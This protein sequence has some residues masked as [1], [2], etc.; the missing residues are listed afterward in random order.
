MNLPNPTQIDAILD[1]A[2]HEPCPGVEILFGQ[3]IGPM[4][5]GR[6]QHATI[7]RPEVP[8]GAPAPAL[9]ALHGGG[10]QQGDPNGCGERGK[11]LAIALGMTTVSVSYRL[12]GENSPTFPGVLEDVA[13]GWRWVHQRAES[14]GLDPSRVAVS[15]SSAGV[16]LGAH[17]V[18][19]S[20]L[21]AE[22]VAGYPSPSAFVA[23]WGPLDLVARWFDNGE[24][25]GA[26]NMLLGTTYSADPALY[27]QASPLTHVRGPLPPALFLYGRQDRVVHARQGRLGLAA[28]GN[29]Q[30]HAEY[31]VIDNIGHGV[32]GDN[33]QSRHFAIHKAA[34]FLASR[35]IGAA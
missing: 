16:L 30:A 25:A 3:D 15:G 35:L 4:W 19:S 20:P 7:Y 22:A 21:L 5:Q 9:M 27:H 33:R 1:L 8:S 26:E 23:Q 2:G 12:A 11:Y 6:R 14:L 18:V 13:Q 34:E 31:F 28:W 10:F 24:N 32:V 29:R 17:L